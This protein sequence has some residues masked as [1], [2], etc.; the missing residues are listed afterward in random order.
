[1]T[2]ANSEVKKTLNA[3][4]ERRVIE[5]GKNGT[6]WYRKWSDGW[7]EQG[8]QIEANI[9]Q[10]TVT[11]PKAFTDSNYSIVFVPFGGRTQDSPAWIG[12]SMA[13]KTRIMLAFGGSANTSAPQLSWVA[14]GY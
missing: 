1:M 6:T 9:G 11:F 12:T 3:L 2:T 4:G 10:A 13:S 5:A 14:F 7:I 8:G